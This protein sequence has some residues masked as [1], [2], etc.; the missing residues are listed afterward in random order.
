MRL[1][2][3]NNT[4]IEVIAHHRLLRSLLALAGVL[5]LLLLGIYN[6]PYYP[7]TWLD[8][9]FALQGPIN[10]VRY[11]QYAM[12]S[13]EGFRVL[14]Q[15]L[16]ANG[17]GIVLPLSAA[18]ALFGVGLLQAR[19]VVVVYLVLTAMAFFTLARRL[20]GTPAAIISI[21]LLLAFPQ[22]G[23]LKYGRYALGNVPALG[24]FLFGY[25]L[26]L[27]SLERDNWG[28]ALGGGLMFGLA[29]VTKGQYGLLIPMLLLVA[30]ADR[31]YY[32]TIGLKR[33]ALVLLTALGCLG[34][35]YVAQLVVVGPENFDQHLA[36]IRS[37]SRVTVFAFRPMRIPRNAWYL[38]RSGLPLFVAPGLIYAAWA[39]RKRGSHYSRHLPLVVFVII[40][41]VWYVFASVGWPRYAFD[42]YAVG[43]LLAGKFLVDVVRFLPRDRSPLNRAG[44]SRVFI[45]AGALLFI[46]AVLLSG[47][48]G[49]TR[50]VSRIVDRPDRPAQLFAEYLQNNVGSQAVV[51]S[52]DWQIDVLADLNYHHPPNA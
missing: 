33:I 26:W 43:T 7:G 34:I 18:F 28:Y 6:Q 1:A 42:A 37:S 14:D 49:L 50:Q 52:W 40:W 35:W 25:L 29:M 17:P 3:V 4:A 27:T 47:I 39:C 32:K 48:W 31:V 2:G 13:A 9:G 44:Q 51:E 11:G 30:F 20:Y 16:I 38:I 21:L 46:V 22:E 45:R 23:F 12:K 19:L 15:P 41:L 8:E 24:Y 10:L 36:A 5:V